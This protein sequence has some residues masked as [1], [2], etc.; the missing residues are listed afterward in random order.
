MKRQ[1]KS[2]KFPLRAVALKDSLKKGILVGVAGHVAIR[3][4]AIPEVL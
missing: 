3:S 4:L 1:K 2:N